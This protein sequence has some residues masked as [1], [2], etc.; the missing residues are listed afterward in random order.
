[1]QTKEKEAGKTAAEAATQAEDPKRTA[2]RVEK[3]LTPAEEESKLQRIWSRQMALE[4]LKKIF[5]AALEG[6]RT[7]ILDEDGALVEVKF[8]PSAANAA[9]KAIEVANRML[10]YTSPEEE[11]ENGA[12]SF[13]VDLGEAEEFAV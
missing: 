7:E 10:G 11:E 6:A 2:E 1:M 3:P 13:T 12:L 4:G 5:T 8:N 9:T